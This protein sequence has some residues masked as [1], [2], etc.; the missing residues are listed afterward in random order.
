MRGIAYV[1]WRT[2]Y[3]LGVPAS[4]SGILDSQSFSNKKDWTLFSA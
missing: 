2:R 3:T 1:P 4:L